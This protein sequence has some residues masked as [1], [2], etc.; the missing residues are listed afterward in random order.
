M[1]T[2]SY[3]NNNNNNQ[4]PLQ[5]PPLRQQQQGRRRVGVL[6]G[7]DYNYRNYGNNP[8]NQNYGNYPIYP[9]QYPNQYPNGNLYRRN[10]YYNRNYQNYQQQRRFNGYDIMNQPYIPPLQQIPQQR[11]LYPNQGR[12][13]QPTRARS[14]SNQ[15][16]GR[17]QSRQPQQQQQRRRRPRQLRLNDFMPTELRDP[18][19]TAPNLPQ[20][21][22]L[23]TI[24]APP[25]ALPQRQVFANAATTA[26]Y[27]N[28]TTQPFMVNQNQQQQTTTTSSNRRQQRRG[29]QQQNQQ[30]RRNRR[31][32]NYN[33]F[34]E[35]AEDNNND[36]DDG[37]V[38]IDLNNEPIFRNKNRRDMKKKK[39]RLYLES[40]RMLRWFEDNSK[41][42][43]NS[44][45]GRGNQAYLLATAPI[46]DEWVRNNYEL[47]IWQ[48][49]LKMGT[50]QKH[51]AKE[52]V[53]RTKKR[54]ETTNCRFINKKI[55][56]IMT[57]I[58]QA[59]ATISDLQIELSTYWMQNSS[60][61]TT[62]KQAH[63]TAELTTNLILERTG[64][65]STLAKNAV[66]A[67]TTTTTAGSTTVK[68]A[69]RD[70]VDRLEKHILDYIHHCTQHVKK[71]AETRVQLAKAQMAEFKA[72][73]DFEQIAAPSQW[74]IHVLLK[75]KMKVWSTKNKNHRTVLKRIEYD[76]PPKFISNIEFKFKIDES[77]LS[78]D[79]SQA[80]YNQMSKMTKDFR[81]QAMALY[82][83]SLGREHELLT[84]E[85]KRIIDGFPNENDDGFDAE[86]GCAAFKQ[87]HEL[88]EKRFNLETDQS[89][90]FLDA[91]QITGRG[92]LA[93]AIINQANITLTEQ[94]HQLLK[95]GPQ[96]IF[97]DPKTASRRRTTELATLKRKIEARFFE[98][99]VSPGSPVEQFIAKLDVLL[100]NLHNIP[101][102]KK[103][104]QFNRIQ[105]NKSFET[106]SSIIQSSQL[107]QSQAIIRPRKKKNYGRIVKRL[108]YKIHLAN[109]ILR[110]TDKSKVFHLGKVGHYQKKSEEY[111]DNT[112]AYQC[113]GVIDP[114]PDLIQRTN[115]YLL[116][117]RLVKWITQK[118]YEQLSIK[119]NEVELAHLYYLPKAH[120]P[121]TPLRPIISG[122]KHP[123]I[124]IS[125]FLDDLLR[126]LFDQMAL[127]STVTSG[128]D[129]VKQLQQWSRN[130]LKQETLFCTID[131]TDLYTMVPQ[132]EGVLSLRK[133]LDQLKLK[134]VGKLK[135]ET[136]IRLSRFVMK[137]NYFSYNGQ[138]YHQIR[139]GAMG[140]P[141]TLTISNCYMYF[142][143]RQ[144][145]NQI[146]NSGGLY[147]RYNDD[148]FVTINW[149][150]RHL[151]KEVDRWN[152][153]DENINLSAN[154]GSTVNF[155]DLNMENRDGQLYTTVFQKPSYE[156]YYLP[157]NS[158]HPLHMKKNIPFAMLLRAIR[159]CSTFQSYLNE[160]EKLRMALLLNKYPNK[161]I[162]EQF[163][164][165]LVKFGINE[166]LTSVNYNRFRQKIID[167]PIKEK[168]SVNYDKSIFVHFTY[169]SSMKTFPIKF[170]TLW[171][172]YFDKSPINEVILI[173]GTR[174]ADNLQK[175]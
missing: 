34:A 163:D 170:H 140:S 9:N 5:P 56:Q 145:V 133:M 153:F 151:L 143:E 93:P 29:G 79:E 106:L 119:P 84:N 35:L 146:R 42:S 167:S 156:P 17:S 13:G 142:F 16:R 105:T 23:E 49:Y 39:T 46:Y 88:R 157:F 103:Q 63:T 125:K 50:E 20:E 43:K 25:D 121:G 55:N 168:L 73:E 154:I 87:Y 89:I 8:V 1:S 98:K 33:R 48:T 124:K 78:P 128:F 149:P 95:L 15:N 65:G 107:S 67:S 169:C 127:N 51:W 14:G 110:K 52:V 97:D 26:S 166:P 129:L 99:K 122:L 80:L 96:F 109:T 57:S 38:E 30:N 141:L 10:I 27:N 158:I 47:Q 116:D 174:N 11:R 66:P 82:M 101:T 134:Q 111:M 126:P 81:T 123:T 160:R 135:D 75:P 70:P 139:G 74:N 161:I 76:L 137:N 31:N 45:S 77:I 175:G 165:V 54:D 85:I 171:N 115:K 172:K 72:L 60:E 86:A 40:N 19:P 138:F 53:Q 102:T 130:H 91:Q 150:V 100:Q 62:Q 18:S 71:V 3:T 131:V 136:I 113:L 12:I 117:L 36:N 148:I 68:S 24:P 152:K 37:P 21:F 22:Y 118:Q 120:K 4:V 7:N 108:K 41:N 83:Q 94:E 159:Y 69:H 32:S 64:L 92:F 58:A 164:N 162:D 112:K 173:L 6:G 155:L 147:F 61:I 44:A 2:I 104:L 59:S 144:I 28:N 90:Y 114:L 132:I